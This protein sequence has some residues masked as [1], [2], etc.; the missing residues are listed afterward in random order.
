MT[1]VLDR[2]MSMNPVNGTTR[3]GAY[4]PGAVTDFISF[5]SETNTSV[6]MVSFASTVTNDVPMTNIFKTTI[7]TAMSNFP[8][9]GGTFAPGGLTNALVQNNSVVVPPGQN[10]LKVV[11][12]FTDGMA[13]VIQQTLGCGQTFNFGGYDPPATGVAFFNPDAPATQTGQ[14]YPLC[15]SMDYGTPSCCPGTTQFFSRQNDTF[16]PFTQASVAAESRY[17]SID[18]ANQIRAQGMYVFSIGL[19]GS[20]VD[21]SFLQQVANDPNSPTLDPSQPV[22]QAVIANDPTQLQSVFQQIA[23]EIL[24][25]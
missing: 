6:A 4:L 10:T 3:G 24:T 16:E 8:Y 5:F 2:S 23:S 7:I 13:N 14:A 21:L 22:G 12:F 15:V 25:Y 1:L 17:Q 18:F 11:V 19:G 20:G 9:A